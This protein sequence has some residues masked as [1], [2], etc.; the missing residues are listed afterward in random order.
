MTN[1]RLYEKVKRL[2]YLAGYN[3]II[4]EV[5]WDYSHELSISDSRRAKVFVDYHD[6]D[7]HFW[8]EKYYPLMHKWLND[9]NIKWRG[10][11]SGDIENTATGSRGFTVLCV[12]LPNSEHL[13]EFSLTWG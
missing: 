12:Q 1:Y 9:R 4:A 2:T 11:Q 6:Q 10:I 5:N 8:V 7:I 13:L 3:F